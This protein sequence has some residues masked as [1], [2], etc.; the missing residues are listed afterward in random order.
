MSTQLIGIPME[1]QIIKHEVLAAVGE[2]ADS[3]MF[4]SVLNALCQ[5]MNESSS[6]NPSGQ[7]FRLLQG[8]Y[9][10]G[11]LSEDQLYGFAEKFGQIQLRLNNIS[12]A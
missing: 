1:L 8:F 12:E 2:T 4:V 7:I 11:K 6:A 10:A 3:T 9:L 5:L